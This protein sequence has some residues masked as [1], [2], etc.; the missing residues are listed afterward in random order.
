[1]AVVT[2]PRTSIYTVPVVLERTNFPLHVLGPVRGEGRRGPL[3][4]GKGSHGIMAPKGPQTCRPLFLTAKYGPTARLKL[5]SMLLGPSSCRAA[6]SQPSIHRRTQKQCRTGSCG[7][8]LLACDGICRSKRRVVPYRVTRP[9][10]I[11]VV[12]SYPLLASCSLRH[13]WTQLFTDQAGSTLLFHP[14]APWG[15]GSH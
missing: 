6:L 11:C 10:C 8:R 5:H 9:S 1:M 12:A 4:K 3:P 2:L 7:I 13:A 15:S 14:T